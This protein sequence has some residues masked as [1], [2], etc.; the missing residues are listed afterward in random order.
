MRPQLKFKE[1]I[2]N[3]PVPFV[4]K[5]KEKPHSQKPLAILL[6]INDFGDEEY[7]HP[8]EFELEHFKPSDE[9]LKVSE[10]EITHFK[11]IE[12][13]PLVMVDTDEGLQTM[14]A[15]LCAQKEIAVD[16]EVTF[17]P[18]LPRIYVIVIIS[19]KS[20]AHSYRS[21]QGLTCLM[22]ISSATTDYIVDT[23][24]LWDNL[25]CLNEVFCNPKIVKVHQSIRR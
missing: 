25:Q 19:L 22:Q 20:Q 10:G 12:E 18:F 5:I 21:F 24:E 15:D 1:K 2:I 9:F 13:T 23:F 11:K 7:S 17:S 3:K 16:L 6:E 4:P 8:Y 14:L